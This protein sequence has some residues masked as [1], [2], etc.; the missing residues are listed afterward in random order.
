MLTSIYITKSGTYRNFDNK[1]EQNNHFKKQ[2]FNNVS[3]LAMNTDS[4]L[5][6]QKQ[7]AFYTNSSSK[8]N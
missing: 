8:K 6:F 1:N 4:P 5:D 3:I 7:R 2:L